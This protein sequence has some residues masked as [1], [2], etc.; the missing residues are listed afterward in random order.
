VGRIL[1]PIDSSPVSPD[2]ARSL[3]ES[4]MDPERFREFCQR[5]EAEF[6]H[7]VPGIGRFRVNCFFQR[8]SAGCVCRYIPEHVPGFEEL[9]LP[10]QTLKQI[11]ALPRGLV[12]VTGPTGCGK[13]TTLASMIAYINDNYTYHVMAIED[14]VEYVHTNRKSIVN[15]REVGIDTLNF[16]SALRHVLRQNPDVILI[17]ELRDLET[18]SIAVTAA[19]TGHLVFGTLHT[20]DAPSSVD[21]I[22]DVFPEHQQRQIRVQLASSLQAIISQQ[23]IPRVG[24]DGVVPAVEIL[25]ATPAVRNLIR[26]NKAFQLYSVIQ[27][28]M[29]IGMRTMNQALAELCRLG[30]VSVD[31]ALTRCTDPE[32]FK[33]LVACI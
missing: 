8:G 32:E 23:L 14:P 26:E 21:R 2:E 9:G 28:N 17:G 3:V 16:T 31:E 29:R 25:L 30:Q 27:S 4:M 20:Y 12:L 5:L 22:V 15:Q 18:I 33:S 6:A 1:K 11:C 10:A 19:E 13:S 24:G 7:T